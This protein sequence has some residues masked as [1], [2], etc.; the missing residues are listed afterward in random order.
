MTIDEFL[1][2]GHIAESEEIIASDRYQALELFSSVFTIGN[3]IAKQ[4]YDVH[5]C[6][7]MDDLLDHYA[8]KEAGEWDT[9]VVGQG[10][11]AGYKSKPGGERFGTG[12]RKR[13]SRDAARRRKEGKMSQAEI[14]REWVALKPDLDKKIPRA[15]VTEIAECVKVHLDALMPGCRYTVTGGYRRGKSESNDVDVVI[16]PPTDDVDEGQ[17]L[18]DLYTRMADLGEYKDGTY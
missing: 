18:R 1:E 5:G 10:I 2:T 11:P 12:E 4:L 16:C 7:T 15:E 17:L 14:V 13:R 3:S 9:G 6:R 8:L